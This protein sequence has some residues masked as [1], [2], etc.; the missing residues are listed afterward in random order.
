MLSSV[1]RGGKVD[2]GLALHLLLLLPLLADGV[3]AMDCSRWSSSP[4]SNHD[5]RSLNLIGPDVHWS[6]EAKGRE[7]SII[8]NISQSRG[9]W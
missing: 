6:P 3:A 7:G 9:G 4:C 5:L 2:A 1:G 8:S